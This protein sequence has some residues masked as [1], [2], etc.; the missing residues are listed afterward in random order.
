M[1]LC[2][3]IAS[4]NQ[5][6]FHQFTSSPLATILKLGYCMLLH[7]LTLLIK[8]SSII[9]GI[10]IPQTH[11]PHSHNEIRFAAQMHTVVLTDFHFNLILFPSYGFIA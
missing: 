10:Q 9:K 5:I 8:W 2:L 11:S 1:K 7:S 6:N 4:L 3:G